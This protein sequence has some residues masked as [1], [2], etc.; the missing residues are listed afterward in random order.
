MNDCQLLNFPYHLQLQKSCNEQNATQTTVRDNLGLTHHCSQ[1]VYTPITS[2]VQIATSNGR[3]TNRQNKTTTTNK[4]ST[5]SFRVWSILR[6]YFLD[7]YIYINIYIYIYV[8][9]HCSPLICTTYAL[10]TC[11]STTLTMRLPYFD[12][13][14]RLWKSCTN[15]NRTMKLRQSLLVDTFIGKYSTST[16]VIFVYLCTIHCTAFS[17]NK[18]YKALAMLP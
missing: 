16:P 18:T 4:R 5:S 9:H 2:F 1:Q 12:H 7:I 8:T 11:K 3:S 6:I 17:I 10:L 13:H 15:K 14:L